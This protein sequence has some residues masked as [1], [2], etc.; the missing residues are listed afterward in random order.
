MTIKN[1]K[2]FVTLIASSSVL[3]SYLYGAPLTFAAAL[4]LNITG[5]NANLNTG[6]DLS[7]GFI[8][9]STLEY[10]AASRVTV[11]IN[12]ANISSVNLNGQVGLMDVTQ[13]A[14]LGSIINHQLGRPVPGNLAIT[15]DDS[16]LTLT[17][18]SSDPIG[19]ASRVNF[20]P[21]NDYSSLGDINF[22]GNS[23]VLTVVAPIT[24]EG[25]F[26][27]G[28]IQHTTLSVN[29]LLTTTHE[30]VARIGTINIFDNSLLNIDG[31]RA[32]APINLAD[33]TDINLRGENSTLKLSHADNARDHAFVLKSNLESN[34]DDYGIIE[35]S[36]NAAGKKLI[37]NQAANE[38]MGIGHRLK[39]LIISGTGDTEVNVESKAQT[40]SVDS[41]GN[42]NFTKEASSG[43]N[44]SLQF[45]QAGTVIFNEDT[46][47]NNISFASKD[48]TIA[49]R[50]GKK[51]TAN[52]TAESNEVGTV[53]FTEGGELAGTVSNLKLLKGGSSGNLKLS[54]GTYNIKEISANGLKKLILSDN[55]NLL[56]RID[57]MSGTN[58]LAL[59]FQGSGK[60]K[61]DVL[62]GDINIL[63]QESLV[64]FESMVKSRN[65]NLGNKSTLKLNGDAMADK[66][67]AR[68]ATIQ[69]NKDLHLKG[70]IEGH[71]TT[72][73]L[74]SNSVTY[75]GTAVFS[76]NVAFN[77]LWDSARQDIGHFII[78]GAGSNLNLASSS[79]VINLTSSATL[80]EVAGKQYPL[81]LTQGNGTI[82]P[83]SSVTVASKDTNNN[84]EW[85][86]NAETHSLVAKNPAEGAPGS[87]EAN[88][89]ST[90]ASHTKAIHTAVSNASKSVL[91]RLFHLMSFQTLSVA[92]SETEEPILAA[93][94]SAGDEESDPFGVWGSLIYNVSHQKPIESSAGYRI[95]SFGKSIGVDKMLSDGVS[96]G[97]S[98]T[99]F[100]THI[101]DKAP[102][103]TK[104]KVDTS[105]ISL[106]GSYWPSNN[107]FVQGLLSF[108][109]NDVGTRK[110]NP[111]T[112]ELLKGDY[113][114]HSYEAETLCGY[115]Y[116]LSESAVLSPML[117]IRYTAY[118]DPSYKETGASSGNLSVEKKSSNKVEA[119]AG[120]KFTTMKTLDS[121]MTI[122]PE[123]HGFVN[124]KVGGKAFKIN[125]TVGSSSPA[126]T[127]TTENYTKTVWSGGVTL[128][129]KHRA[130]EYSVGYDAHLSKKYVGHQGVLKI[131]VKI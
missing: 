82:T 1:K 107:F 121:G 71:D 33:G 15:I 92:S 46:N 48:G 125:A 77:V 68:D 64:E 87:T 28:R 17:G 62:V 20:A 104:T 69:I 23:P 40:I 44:S 59:E 53:E 58:S 63:G 25:T 79:V 45:K 95:H 13:N 115:N 78:D 54:S 124:Q 65:I 109:F 38:G 67:L 108:S 80:D 114:S 70:N 47:I 85:L 7:A 35:L 60:I 16:T 110:V 97:A 21:V 101:K 105:M 129:L 88:H 117:G 72:I 84:V 103:T 55:F 89:H 8:A 74:G 41:T 75:N 130:M 50:Q 5:P 126:L 27:G 90:L 128:S 94:V 11:N 56:G 91:T 19:F 4:P 93:G 86:Y 98:F 10:G 42:I 9:G 127:N 83:S 37:I 24:L 131:L 39:Q 51:L 29:S 106:Y 49:I 122:I 112:L 66:I 99:Y 14:F 32:A 120:A 100:N 30:S 116:A 61:G 96:L 26:G 76:G 81:L 22:I 18:T 3:I 52:I 111:V 57:D 12:G 2:S 118:K 73:E 31:T 119:I 6:V 123:I 43:N 36:S 113:R 102:S 34:V